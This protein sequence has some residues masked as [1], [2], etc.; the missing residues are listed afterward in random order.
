LAKYRLL[1][2]DDSFDRLLSGK[3]SPVLQLRLT[4]D[5]RPVERALADAATAFSYNFARY[6]DEVRYT[7][8]VLRF[9]AVFQGNVRLAPPDFPVRSPDHAL[10]Y[11]TVTG[12]PAGLGSF[13]M[14]AVRWLTRPRQIAVLVTDAGRARFEAELFHFGDA[15]RPMGAEL[16]LLEPGQYHL[17]LTAGAKT[18]DEAA[19]TVSGPRTQVAF[20]L[21]ARQ[22][23]RLTL[24]PK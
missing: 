4:G 14:N 16:Y 6:A 20:E 2:G 13:P 3:G 7:D 12:D 24:T 5:R 15:P 1:T 9:P 22:A 8:R 17:R 10:L 21:P 18:L 23:C 11:S 19:V